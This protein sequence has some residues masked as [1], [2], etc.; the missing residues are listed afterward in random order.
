MI[1][2]A[3]R[4]YVRRLSWVN[5]NIFVQ[6]LLFSAFPPYVTDIIQI[7]KL[8]LIRKKC[9]KNFYILFLRKGEISNCPYAPHRMWSVL[10]TKIKQFNYPISSSLKFSLE[11]NFNSYNAAISNWNFIIRNLRNVFCGTFNT[12]DLKNRKLFHILIS[13]RIYSIIVVCNVFLRKALIRNYF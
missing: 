10:T 7:K 13:T 11:I 4:C 12:S 1:S 9:I 2:D 5:K 8:I 6:K 3:L